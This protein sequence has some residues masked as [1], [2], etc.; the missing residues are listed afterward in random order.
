MAVLSALS[1]ADAD[2]SGFD[3]CP[4][5]CAATDRLRRYASEDKGTLDPTAMRLLEE[6]LAAAAE[7]E[8]SIAA[9]HARIRY[10]ESLSVTDELTGLFNRR[11]FEDELRRALA[12]ANRQEET[13]VLILCDLDHFKAIND[14]YGHPA[15]DRILTAVAR[16]LDESTRETD[17]VCRI[18]GDEFALIFTHTTIVRAKH[19]CRRLERDLNALMIPWQ[20]AVLGVSASFGMAP[21]GPGSDLRGL[22]QLADQN[23]YLKKAHGRTARDSRR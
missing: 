18:G 19:R 8:Q 13:G 3:P 22:Y 16:F 20:S 5:L 7:A 17:H 6:A 4:Q 2:G 11:G 9:Q 15:G 23:L 21:Y 14:T 10:L 1:A 12:R